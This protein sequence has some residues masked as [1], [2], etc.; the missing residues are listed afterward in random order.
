M[1][2]ITIGLTRKVLAKENE[3]SVPVRPPPE[4]EPVPEPIQ[5]EEISPIDL[6]ARLDNSDD[7]IVVDMPRPG[8][9]NRDIFRE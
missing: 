9:I 8:S 6:R 2:E 1:E 4:S 5:I 7:L 3:K